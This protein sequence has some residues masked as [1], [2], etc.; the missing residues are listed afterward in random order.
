MIRLQILH[1]PLENE[2]MVESW[3]VDWWVCLSREAKTLERAFC[4]WLPQDQKVKITMSAFKNH[5]M[6]CSVSSPR[7]HSSFNK[8]MLW[9]KRATLLIDCVVVMHLS[10]S[11]CCDAWVHLQ[12]TVSSPVFAIQEASQIA[13][14]MRWSILRFVHA[15][16]TDHQEG[17][18][19]CEIV[20]HQ[21]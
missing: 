17:P 21:A 20:A 10:T 5:R 14:L 6:K 9:W 11:Q 19:T 18:V 3:M 15:I 8:S 2:L 12:R 16:W 4:T 1:P 13:C 7:D